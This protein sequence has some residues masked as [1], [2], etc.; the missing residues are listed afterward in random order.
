MIGTSLSLLVRLKLENFEAFMTKQEHDDLVS[1][2]T[3]SKLK[4]NLCILFVH[5]FPVQVSESLLAEILEMMKTAILVEHVVESPIHVRIFLDKL[6]KASTS[7]DLH[8]EHKAFVDSTIKDHTGYN[9]DADGSESGSD[10]ERPSEHKTYFCRQ[11]IVHTELLKYLVEIIE[12]LALLNLQ[13]F[14]GTIESSL[15]KL[16]TLCYDEVKKSQFS[17]LLLLLLEEYLIWYFRT[18]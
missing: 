16:M 3:S 12:G 7:P 8:I 9:Y 17:A 6:L 5:L 18:M 4:S 13:K 14:D 10:D 1:M 15:A 11:K 2:N